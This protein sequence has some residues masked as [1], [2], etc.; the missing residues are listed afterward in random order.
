M[1]KSLLAM[2]AATA[3]AATPALAASTDRITVTER[4]SN[5]PDVILIPG[6]VSSSAVWDGIAAHLEKDHRLHIVQVDGFAGAPPNGNKDG[7]VIAP[8][9]EAVHDY[10]VAHHLKAPA[11]I[12]HSM[13]GLMGMMLARRHPEDV[14]RLM[15]VD[16]LPFFSVLMG[17]QDVASAEPMA[18]KMRDGLLSASTDGFAQ[19]QEATIDRLVKSPDGRKLA[20]AWSLA[21]DRSVAARAAY[22]AMT[23]DMRTE[24][25]KIAQPVTVLYPWDASSPFPQAATDGLYQSNYAALPHKT[26]QRIDGSYHFIMLDQPAAFAAAVDT[27][28][29]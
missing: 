2:I 8:A 24:L 5:G 1:R 25:P 22:D 16:S 4:G 7:A 10:V 17:A 29:K 6:L 9:M 14:G 19:R 18:A 13:G 12:G 11:V 15:I 28:L 23:T 21:S 27:F 3:I 26:M 20:L